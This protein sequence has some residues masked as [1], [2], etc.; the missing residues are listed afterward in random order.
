M[1]DL[2]IALAASTGVQ[3]ATPTAPQTP[4]TLATIPGVTVKY[5]DVSGKNIG[6]IRESMSKSRPKGAD[7]NP[8]PASTTWTINASIAK[9]TTDGQ[10]SIASVTPAFSGTAELPRLTTAEKLNPEL[11][12]QWNDYVAGLESTAADRMNFVRARLGQVQQAV[13][14]ASCDTASAALDS[15][16]QQIEAQEAAFVAEQT[17]QRAAEEKRILEARKAAQQQQPQQGENPS[18]D[19]KND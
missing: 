11:L 6:Q 2:F 9:R 16:V 14:A 10:C 8:I 7:G 15:A 18:Y 19:P 12:K 4:A 5:Y 13:G 1:F 3:A 17:A